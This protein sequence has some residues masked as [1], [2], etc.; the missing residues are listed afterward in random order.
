MKKR[1]AHLTYSYF[2]DIMGL[3]QMY[4]KRIF[5]RKN[6]KGDYYGSKHFLR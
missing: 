5:V 2:A 6:R 4:V 1:T 3:I